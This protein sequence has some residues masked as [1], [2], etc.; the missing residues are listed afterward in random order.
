MMQWRVSD[1]SSLLNESSLEI[2][3]TRLISIGN[4]KWHYMHGITPC[5]TSYVEHYPYPVGEHGLYH[6][7][8][9]LD[10]PSEALSPVPTPAD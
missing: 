9:P 10:L 6:P 8:Y 7:L 1:G 4:Q 3:G 2:P 5:T